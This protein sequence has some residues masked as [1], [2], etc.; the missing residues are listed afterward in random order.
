M[1]KTPRTVTSPKKFVIGRGLLQQMHDY[2]KDFGDNAFI[3]SDEFILPRV[4]DEAVT[5]LQK[6]GL[7]VPVKNLTTNVLK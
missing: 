5:G 7:K 4:K 3:I 1:N 2:V 6:A